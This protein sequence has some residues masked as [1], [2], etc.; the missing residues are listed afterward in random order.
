MRQIP[1]CPSTENRDH[2]DDDNDDDDQIHWKLQ[3]RLCH[4]GNNKFETDE[5]FYEQFKLVDNCQMSIKQLK[6]VHC[7]RLNIQLMCQDKKLK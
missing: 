7:Q 6:S 1:I 3:I 2:D 4:R 5:T